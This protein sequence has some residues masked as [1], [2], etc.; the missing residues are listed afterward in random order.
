MSK[1][2]EHKIIGLPNDTV[3]VYMDCLHLVVYNSPEKIVEIDEY[4]INKF[5]AAIKSV[6]KEIRKAKK[7]AARK[8]KQEQER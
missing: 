2:T 5:I 4:E 3:S 1:K 7:E 6:K 8:Q